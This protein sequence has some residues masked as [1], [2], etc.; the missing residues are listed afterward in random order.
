MQTYNSSCEEEEIDC[1]L[2]FDCAW[3]LNDP[4]NMP[5]SALDFDRLLPGDEIIRCPDCNALPDPETIH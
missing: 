4:D 2:C 3:V 5:F 1:P